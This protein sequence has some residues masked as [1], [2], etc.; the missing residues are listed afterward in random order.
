MKNKFHKYQDND[1][2]AACIVNLMILYRTVILKQE[3]LIKNYTKIN[4]N[5]LIN[6]SFLKWKI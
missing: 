2:P 4:F 1:S 3:Y 6:V 5:N